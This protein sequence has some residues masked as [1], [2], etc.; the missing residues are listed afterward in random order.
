MNCTRCGGYHM[1]WDNCPKDNSL[2]LF[3]PK[4]EFDPPKPSLDFNLTQYNPP[5]PILPTYKPIEPVIPPPDPIRDIGNNIIGYKPHLSNTIG[6]TP[7]SLP[8]RHIEPG[9][10]VRD[11][12]GNLVG[13]MGPGNIMSPPSLPHMPDYGPP[14][15]TPDAWNPGFSPMKPLG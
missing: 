13:Q 14:Q 10:L 5:E 9:G 15:S 1:L 2:D 6:S 4:F 3:Q 8:D 11:V 7:T 12:M